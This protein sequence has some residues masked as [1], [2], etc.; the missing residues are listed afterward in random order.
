MGTILLRH[1][2]GGGVAMHRAHEG[3]VAEAIPARYDLFKYDGGYSWGY[4]GTGVQA[5]SYALANIAL[6]LHGPVE[7][8]IHRCARVI[9]EDVLCR[10]DSD[11][12]HDVPTGYILEVCGVSAVA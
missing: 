1:V 4:K 12:E 10:L 8:E 5:L 2:E 11:E 3:G 6:R 9:L 7:A